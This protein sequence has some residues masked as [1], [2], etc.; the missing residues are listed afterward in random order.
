PI[1]DLGNGVAPDYNGVTI[2][3]ANGDPATPRIQQPQANSPIASGQNLFVLVWTN[4]GDLGYIVVVTDITPPPPPPAPPPPVM[5]PVPLTIPP[6]GGSYFAAEFLGSN[7]V[8]NHVYRIRV[9]V[10]PAFGATPP[11]M[12]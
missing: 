2:T 10:D 6:P 8:A 4:R 9:Y 11:H 12:D 1:A 5:A 3:D 7:F